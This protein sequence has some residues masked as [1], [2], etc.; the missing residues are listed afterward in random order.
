MNAVLIISILVGLSAAGF[1]WFGWGLLAAF[2][3]RSR[4]ASGNPG[5]DE[6]GDGG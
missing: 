4:A 3:H 1:V 2:T 6:T 5:A